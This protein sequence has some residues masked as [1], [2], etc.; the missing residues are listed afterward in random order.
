MVGCGC[1]LAT[2]KKPVCNPRRLA[3]QSARRPAQAGGVDRPGLP[4]GPVLPD[5]CPGRLLAGLCAP[6]C[7]APELGIQAPPKHLDLDLPSG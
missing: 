3:S 7:V 5:N 2:P 1:V 6:V 4:R